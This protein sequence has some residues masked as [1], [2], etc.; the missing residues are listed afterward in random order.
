MNPC[1]LHPRQSEHGLRR[2]VRME[3][4]KTAAQTAVE[5]ASVSI[6]GGKI[7]AGTAVA[8]PLYVYMERIS[9][10]AINAAEVQPVSTGG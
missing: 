2:G 9:E 10:Y 7:I 1:R 4:G 6:E 3:G 5:L 8:D